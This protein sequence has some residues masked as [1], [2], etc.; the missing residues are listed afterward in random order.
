M[1]DSKKLVDLH[2][3]LTENQE[4]NDENLS[5]F[6]Q[7]NPDGDQYLME[8]ILQKKPKRKKIYKFSIQR[9]IEGKFNLKDKEDDYFK[10][11]I[12]WMRNS[13]EKEPIKLFQNYL[14]SFPE[15]SHIL[16]FL[17]E[18]LTQWKSSDRLFIFL[19]LSNL[20]SKMDDHW[21]TF[22]DFILPI[23]IREI[24]YKY[25]GMNIFQ[26][27]KDLITDQGA[28]QTKKFQ[29]VYKHIADWLLD[30]SQFFCSFKFEFLLEF[31]DDMT[32]EQLFQFLVKFSPENIFEYFTSYFEFFI[33]AF[34][35][36]PNETEEIAIK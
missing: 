10:R 1:S 32:K 3:I 36:Y 18:E 31:I 28:E 19:F 14:N 33:G 8:Y 17:I 12:P 25:I 4:T 23:L 11:W 16:L 27:F 7:K 5:Q 35:K 34:S 26:I 20:N 15:K 22:Y 6:I 9:I 13:K 29:L 21:T 30:D 2:K 24:E